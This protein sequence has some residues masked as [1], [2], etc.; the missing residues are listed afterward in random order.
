LQELITPSALN[1]AQ[2][3]KQTER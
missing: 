1:F 2:K 3:N